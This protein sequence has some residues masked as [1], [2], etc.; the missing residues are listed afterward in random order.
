MGKSRGRSRLPKTRKTPRGRKKAAAKKRVPPKPKAPVPESAIPV[1][2]SECFGDFLLSTKTEKDRISCPVC[3]H[4]GLIDE[5][6]FDEI[7]RARQKH[8]K[9]FLV[10]LVVTGL[11]FLLLLAYGLMN[12]WPLAA[13]R[14]GDSWAISPADETTNM[15]LL[16]LGVLLL[17]VGFVVIN[18]YEKSR[19][20]VYF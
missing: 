18:K 14:E 15:V 4:V 9:N 10:A 17:I 3:G 2:C 16:G 20:E 12:S 8:R 1:V 7:S 11:S 5:G 13:V 19:V 6:T